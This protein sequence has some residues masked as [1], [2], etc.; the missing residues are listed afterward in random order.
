MKET[1]ARVA[2]LARANAHRL[3]VRFMRD[4]PVFGAISTSWGRA[5]SARSRFALSEFGAELAAVTT[6]RMLQKRGVRLRVACL[7]SE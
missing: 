3:S 6:L 4:P 7:Q 2:R 5:V 1:L